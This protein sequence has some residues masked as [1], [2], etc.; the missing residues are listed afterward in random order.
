MIFILLFVSG[1]LI[2]P[3]VL[4]AQKHGADNIFR[5]SGRDLLN[6]QPVQ[7]TFRVLH[8]SASGTGTAAVGVAGLVAIVVAAYALFWVLQLLRLVL[9]VVL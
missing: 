8:V 1:V 9:K 7:A 4:D 5:R 2:V 6:Y 3:F